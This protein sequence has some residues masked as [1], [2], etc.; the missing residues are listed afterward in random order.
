MPSKINVN[1]KMRGLRKSS[2]DLLILGRPAVLLLLFPAEA[3]GRTLRPES[4]GLLH[5]TPGVHLGRFEPLAPHPVGTQ[6]AISS[7]L[8]ESLTLAATWVSPTK[9]GFPVT[10][11]LSVE[12]TTAWG[13]TVDMTSRTTTSGSRIPLGDTS[14]TALG[15]WQAARARKR[16]HKR[17]SLV[18]FIPPYREVIDESP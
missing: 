6:A 7:P 9:A 16:A 17:L 3:V 5:V 2:A 10:A 11:S 8:T 14:C 12:R 1:N 18:H 15:V 4:H 13:T